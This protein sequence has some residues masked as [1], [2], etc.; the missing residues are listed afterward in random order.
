MQDLHVPG[1]VALLCEFLGAVLALKHFLLQVATHVV[2]KLDQIYISLAT[3]RTRFAVLISALDQPVI[4]LVAVLPI[5]V[6]ENEV[7]VRGGRF[8]VT[9]QIGIEVMAVNSNHVLVFVKAINP[10]EFL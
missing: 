2:I 5:E 6:V 8:S 9:E 3:Q 4:R 1:L 10:K 7:L